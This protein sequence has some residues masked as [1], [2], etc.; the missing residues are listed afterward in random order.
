MIESSMVYYGNELVCID[1][2]ET[3]SVEFNFD[4]IWSF[5]Q[6]KKKINDWN[7]ILLRFYHVHPEGFTNYSQTDLNCAKGFKIAFG[8]CLNFNIVIFKNSDINDL[9]HH[10]SCFEYDPEKPSILVTKT[11][12][13]Y[14]KLGYE[15]LFML[16]ALSY[17][18]LNKPNEGV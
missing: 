3:Y 12:D 11:K 18:F 7:P 17:G 6:E 1:L 10:L 16:K 9:T 14:N 13:W 8:S 4:R 5:M 2:G 15:Q